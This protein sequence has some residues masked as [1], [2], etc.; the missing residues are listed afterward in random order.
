V[1]GWEGEAVI[2]ICAHPASQV[3]VWGRGMPIWCWWM[4]TPK[5]EVR[6]RGRVGDEAMSL[7]RGDEWWRV[8]EV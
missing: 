5:S 4:L 2:P 3:Q 8:V 7:R 6:V 1:S